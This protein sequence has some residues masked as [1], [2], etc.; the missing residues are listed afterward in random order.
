MFGAEYSG[1]FNPVERF[2]LD[3]GENDTASRVL[4]AYKAKGMAAGE[5]IRSRNLL[6]QGKVIMIA[7]EGNHSWHGRFQHPLTP[8]TA[9]MALQTAA[10]VIPVVSIGGYTV[11]PRWDNRIWLTGR[12]KVRVGQPFTVC[13]SPIT[14]I[15]DDI[16][17]KTNQLIWDRMN[18]LING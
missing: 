12:I 14:K 11:Q 3:M 7:A 9:W 5:L 17:E 1:G 10:P 16:L 2:L 15:S 18:S 4:R 6:R 13:D 8:G